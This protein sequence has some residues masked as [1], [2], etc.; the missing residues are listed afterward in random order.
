MTYRQPNPS[1]D[2][3]EAFAERPVIE[4]WEVVQLIQGF[5]PNRK[6]SRHGITYLDD[7]APYIKQLKTSIQNGTLTF[8]IKPSVIVHWCSNKNVPLPEY[9]SNA[10]TKTMFKLDRPKKP[11]I[12]TDE[13]IK[14]STSDQLAKK[15]K[16]K[17]GRKKIKAETAIRGYET[18]VCNLAKAFCIEYI[19][20][21]GIL[22]KKKIING[23]LSEKLN[24][25]ES[26]V[27]R[28]YSFTK[29]L[30][31]KEKND[32]AR[33]YRRNKQED[34]EFRLLNHGISP[35]FNFKSLI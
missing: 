10:V 31:A 28:A 29:I 5:C 6:V 19:K 30:T 35:Q 15:H 13:L 12:D 1:K 23:V 2:E 7:Y 8:P 3:L 22:P 34:I 25:S 17:P 4:F 21:N 9:F 32:A 27:N 11:L 20:K 26:D 24:R 16:N 33:Q 14:G 18:T